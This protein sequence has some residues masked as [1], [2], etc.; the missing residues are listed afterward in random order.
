M[1]AERARRRR[2][3]LKQKPKDDSSAP[4][5]A[6]EQCTVCLHSYP[7]RNQVAQCMKRHEE[8][9]DLD[10][11]VACPLCQ[12]V[13]GSKRGVTQHFAE[14]HIGEGRTCCPECLLVMPNENNRLRRHIIKTHH[15]AGKPVICPQCGRTFTTVPQ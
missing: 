14:V 5:A 6:T 4:P 1:R 10:V 8:E 11:E 9:L 2:E 13:I 7:N 15:T 12:V 3:L